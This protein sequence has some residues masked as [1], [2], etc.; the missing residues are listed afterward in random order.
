VVKEIETLISTTPNDGIR[1]R[2]TTVRQRILAATGIAIGFA[3]EGVFGMR[4]RA[5]RRQAPA[6]SMKNAAMLHI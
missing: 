4:G 2:K 1:R 6:Y 3:V 5:R